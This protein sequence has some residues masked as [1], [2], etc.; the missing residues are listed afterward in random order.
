[1]VVVVVV[2]VADDV[3]GNEKSLL[4]SW[5]VAKDGCVGATCDF[6]GTSSGHR[7]I[8]QG[9]DAASPPWTM[10]IMMKMMMMTM[11]MMNH[12]TLAHTHLPSIQECHHVQHV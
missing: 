9:S 4:P 7:H 2:V 1:M 3:V 10:R 6:L 5:S 8:Y 11:T 12:K